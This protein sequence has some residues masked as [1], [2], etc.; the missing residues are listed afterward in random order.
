MTIDLEREAYT[1]LERDTA[2]QLVKAGTTCEICRKAKAV[3]LALVPGITPVPSCGTCAWLPM[4]EIM[5]KLQS[6]GWEE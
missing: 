4:K 5:I 3:G 2:M 6:K 1:K